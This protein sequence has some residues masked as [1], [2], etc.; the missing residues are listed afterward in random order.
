MNLGTVLVTVHQSSQ[1]SQ[2]FG[3]S[4][5]V[6]LP[7]GT[8]VTFYQISPDGPNG[9]RRRSARV[10]E[11]TSWVL[12]LGYWDWAERR[13]VIVVASLGFFGAGGQDIDAETLRRSDGKYE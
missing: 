8:G 1:Y 2:G 6:F 10:R 3:I 12:R 7:D 9:R 5:L 11:C 13:G 4:G